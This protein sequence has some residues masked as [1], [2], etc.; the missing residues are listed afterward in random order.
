M[1]QTALGL[2]SLAALVLAACGGGDAKPAEAA[3][4]A[5]AVTASQQPQGTAGA[6]PTAS[7]PTATAKPKEK[8]ED[9]FKRQLGFLEKGQSGRAYD[10]IHPAQQA[11]IPRDLYM[12][13]VSEGGAFAID[14]LKVIET[15]PEAVRIPGTMVDVDSTAVTVEYTMR[16]GTQTA[17]FTTTSHEILVDGKWRF[18]ASG[19]DEYKAGRCP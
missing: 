11:I 4:T 10:E 2:I 7:T 18:S 14:K 8:A 9:A 6:S 3:E 19:G 5:V 1:K 12:K 16:R 15:Y 13:C 17:T